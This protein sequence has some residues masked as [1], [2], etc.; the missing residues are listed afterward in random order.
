MNE[1]GVIRCS[2]I[3]L[4]W[5]V[6]ALTDVLLYGFIWCIMFCYLA[7]WDAPLFFSWSCCLNGWVH[8]CCLC[9]PNFCWAALA[10]LHAAYYSHCFCYPLLITCWLY[11]L[12]W[13]IFLLLILE[14]EATFLLGWCWP[15]FQS[16]V[17]GHRVSALFRRWPKFLFKQGWPEFFIVYFSISYSFVL[18]IQIGMTWILFSYGY[19][20]FCWN[21]FCLRLHN[22]KKSLNY[23]NCSKYFNSKC[24]KYFS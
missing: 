15:L 13:F 9:I 17:F 11:D 21:E 20:L 18:F 4:F 1:Y 12:C 24:S 2:M 16:L 6:V 8:H 10:M 7:L 23:S 22:E 5:G 19:V 14:V 3:N